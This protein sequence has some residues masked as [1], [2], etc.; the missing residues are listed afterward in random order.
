[1]YINNSISKYNSLKQLNYCNNI[2][3]ITKENIYKKFRRSKIP[4]K[5][6]YHNYNYNS[7]SKINN[8]NERN[9]F[10]SD[11]AN[12]YNISN[13]KNTLIKN[14]SIQS[15]E[16]LSDNKYKSRMN[17]MINN[18]IIKNI[19]VNKNPKYKTSNMK[20]NQK[21]QIPISNNFFNNIKKIKENLYNDYNQTFE[22]IN[23]NR[24]YNITS[25]NNYLNTKSPSNIIKP[26]EYKSFNG[27]T[28]LLNNNKLKQITST[29]NY[30]FYNNNNNSQRK[31]SYG[32]NYFNNMNGIYK[33]NVNIMNKNRKNLI[34]KTNNFYNKTNIYES[35]N[36]NIR[37]KICL[38][39]LQ[40]QNKIKNKNRNN[41]IIK[42]KSFNNIISLT[43]N[44]NK[45]YQY[46][47]NN[48]NKIQNNLISSSSS[49][50]ISYELSILA[51][52]IINIYKTEKRKNKEKKY[53]KNLL[54]KFDKKVKKKINDSTEE[55]FELIDEIINKANLEEKNKEKREINFELEKNIYIN[56]KPKE[57]IANNEKKMEFYLTLLKSKNKFN[58]IIK[59]FDTKEI[60]I[61]KE[62]ILNENLEEYEILGDLYNIFYLKDINDLDK[63]L[64][65][66][67]DNLVKKE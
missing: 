67:I 55:N 58:P 10:Y 32:N 52:D 37:D 24:M 3:N 33:R 43:N 6:P 25:N 16:Q 35:T 59:N 27:K 4:I 47:E 54:K 38:K 46:T 40:V 22:N 14:R 50:D 9:T 23:S 56:Y 41:I 19:F 18:G 11:E 15:F 26:L 8:N 62:Y 21:K 34:Y 44:N 2:L 29:N 20:K 51:E 5:T 1:M 42:N 7:I 28:L 31:N 45:F 61:N 63:K 30:I 57:K 49:S 13:N 48:N 66:N 53:K 17:I 12:I 64:K 39:P 36:N 60:K 65:H